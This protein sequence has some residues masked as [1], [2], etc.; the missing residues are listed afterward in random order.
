MVSFS[1]IAH[2]AWQIYPDFVFGTG[3]E[4]FS[5]VLKETSKNRGEKSYFSSVWNGI[6]EG[7]KAAET[8][9][10]ETL[11][12]HNGSFLKSLWHDLTTT[13]TPLSIF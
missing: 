13:H 2:R 12:A 9:N 7:A 8:H 1:S 5:N 11:A 10:K 6:K 3:N 4:K